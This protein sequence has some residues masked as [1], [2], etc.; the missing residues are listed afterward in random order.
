MLTKAT[1]RKQKLVAI[2][3]ASV[4][5]ATTMMIVL[6]HHGRLTT[7]SRDANTAASLHA[8]KQ[9]PSEHTVY[10]AFNYAKNIANYTLVSTTAAAAVKR[11]A[12]NPQ[13][14]LCAIGAWEADVRHDQDALLAG[15]T[16][17]AKQV[18]TDKLAQQSANS[19]IAAAE[20]QSERN[21]AA[22]VVRFGSKRLVWVFKRV[23]A[24]SRWKLTDVSAGLVVGTF[25]PA[26]EPK[27]VVVN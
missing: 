7:A 16:E 1:T 22:V 15:M 24:K 13:T 26:P 14:A 17:N 4:L 8:L 3:A 6:T 9:H 20:I 12:V 5:L 18:W 21:T 27:V 23:T 25:K 11:C 10:Y 19:L 2:A